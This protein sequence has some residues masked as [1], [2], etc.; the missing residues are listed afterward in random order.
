[1]LLLVLFPFLLSLLS[2]S[3]PPLPSFRA[4]ST[5][6]LVPIES[7]KFKLKSDETYLERFFFDFDWAEFCV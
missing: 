5:P 4:F 3:T 7:F 2:I 6:F 1:M